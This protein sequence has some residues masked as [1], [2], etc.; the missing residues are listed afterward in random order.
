M[1]LDTGAPAS[2]ID[3]RFGDGSMIDPQPGRPARR[4]RAGQCLSAA[5]ATPCG[6]GLERPGP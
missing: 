4:E 5:P 2:S 3:M 1:T 6:R